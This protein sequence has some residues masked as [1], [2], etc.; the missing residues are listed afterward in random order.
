VS[1]ARSNATRRAALMGALA[2]IGACATLRGAP[3]EP[4]P[5]IRLGRG[6]AALDSADF[7]VAYDVLSS[8]Y[9]Q[10]QDRP[11]GREAL[12]A[13]AAVAVDPRNPDRRLDVGANLLQRYFADGDVAPAEAP[14]L[15]ALYLLTLEL[16]ARDYDAV[17]LAA[18]ADSAAR[19]S[20]IALGDS[21]PARGDSAA[22]RRAVL[23]GDARVLPVTLLPPPLL[24]ASSDSSTRRLPSLP[25]QP[26][27]GRLQILQRTR[28]RLQ[29]V[30]DR[31]ERR[32]KDL[33]GQLSDAKKELERIRKT[34][35]G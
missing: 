21:I 15:R 4:D 28:G 22:T 17:R 24:F 13:L 12:L 34:L 20:L 26:V 27:T 14:A 7:H 10:Y 30:S 1:G 2:L 18:L 31:L 35:H 25:G 11:V 6:L 3:S 32:V 8:L 16:G 33:Q 9:A 29:D 19:D 23:G 5:N